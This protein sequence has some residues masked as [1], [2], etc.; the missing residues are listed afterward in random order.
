M[1]A[2][3]S[4][5]LAGPQSARPCPSSVPNP[6]QGKGKRDEGPAAVE[7]Q[8]PPARARACIA[9]ALEETGWSVVRRGTGRESLRASRTVPAEELER[10]AETRRAAEI[11]WA[12][13]RVDLLAGFSP[14]GR[15]ATRLELRV[16]VLAEGE[17]SAPL[18]RPTN[19]WPLPSTG[20]LEGE[21]AAAL[22]T[23]CSR[24]D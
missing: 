16:R 22:Q 17:T 15:N 4:P 24:R 9:A 18:M 23:R 3:V 8:L 6:T 20:A 7:L 21:L 10:I 14:L 11:R 5:A 19:W 2:L 13:G 12:H 1:L